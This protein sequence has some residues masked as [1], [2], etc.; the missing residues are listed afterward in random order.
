MTDLLPLAEIEHLEWATV[1]VAIAALVRGYTGFGFAAIAI[2]GL[3]LIWPPQLSVPVILL[4]DLIGSLGLLG[5]ASKAFSK[6]LVVRLGL[7][8]LAGIPVGLLVLTQ[9][10]ESWLKLLISICVLAMTLA[11][12]WR[13]RQGN[14]PLSNGITSLI[15]AVSGAFT[16]AASVGGL[17]VVCYLLGT[18]L[19]ARAQRASMVVFLA[20]TDL[21]ALLVLYLHGVFDASLLAPFLMLLLPTLAGVQ[22]GQWGFHRFKPESFHPVALPVLTLLS[23]SGV[24]L[25]LY[26]IF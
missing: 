24:G 9:V 14:R 3:N 17:P 21:L 22:L 20:A 6:P 15:G 25:G 1:L 7:G 26:R 23:V 12:I 5:A 11:L 2:T 13:P 8:A 4:L 10:P 16:A 18:G 19:S